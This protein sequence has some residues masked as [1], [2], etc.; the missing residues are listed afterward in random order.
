[1]KFDQSMK[2]HL[3]SAGESECLSLLMERARYSKS[4]HVLVEKAAEADLIVLTGNFGRDPQ[5][6][7]QHP[8]YL[9]F[10]DK[11]SV[12]TEDDNYLPLAPGVYC[13]AEV[14]SSSRA[15]RTFSYA[16]ISRNGRYTNPFVANAEAIE[17]KYL[18]TF[19]GGSTSMLRKRLFNIQFNRP[20]VVIE[21]TSTYYHWDLTQPDRTQRQQ[22]YAETLAASHFVLCPRGAGT[23]SI[24][25]FEVMNSGV[26]PVLI[27]DDYLLPKHI[28]WDRF[29]L[30]IRE[31]DIERLPELLEPHRATSEERGR[32]AR[33][34][35]VANFSVEVEFDQIIALCSAAVQHGPPLEAAFRKQQT[36]MIARL[37]MKG[38]IRTLAKAAALK[39]MKILH[40]KNPYQMNER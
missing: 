15:D 26:A 14:D 21:N 36:R 19:Q 4:G 5:L 22:A 1:M 7:L 31:R 25:L 40:I 18:F 2:I 38:Q 3:S 35:F 11:C 17:K 23:G 34:A 16:Y 33:E 39:T 20:D 29:L 28:D 6:L 12:Y 30:R 13:S 37:Q 24:R 27:A 32:L 10:P 9:A 8:D